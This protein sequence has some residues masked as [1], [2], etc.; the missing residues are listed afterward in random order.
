MVDTYMTVSQNHPEYAKD[1][2]NEFLRTSKLKQEVEI[3]YYGTEK[4]EE[5]IE[6]RKQDT[7]DLN[8]LANIE[9][10]KNLARQ[11]RD[12]AEK[13]NLL[14]PPVFP[15]HERLFTFPKIYVT[16]DNLG[17]VTEIVG[18]KYN[19]THT[20]QRIKSFIMDDVK[21][22]KQLKLVPS[23]C[24]I[25]SVY[26]KKTNSVEVRVDKDV[27]PNVFIRV[28]K[29]VNA[30]NKHIVPPTGKDIISSYNLCVVKTSTTVSA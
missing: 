19:P 25:V 1:Y 15:S 26:D 3:Y 13:N 5:E 30:Y 7:E 9:V 22:A 29:I 2:F 21:K 18:N 6:R 28:R 16:R 11:K 10:L 14:Q 4:G 20:I 12:Y 27:D 17:Q 24:K 23:D 8:E